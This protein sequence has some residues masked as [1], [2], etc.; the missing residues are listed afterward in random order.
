[1][2]NILRT[3]D[4]IE[5]GQC[6]IPQTQEL[7]YGHETAVASSATGEDVTVKDSQT[8]PVPRSKRQRQRRLLSDDELLGEF[9]SGSGHRQISM[10]LLPFEDARRIREATVIESRE[11]AVADAGGEG[12]LNPERPL[13]RKL[14]STMDVEQFTDDDF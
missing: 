5:R 3:L 8:Q 9:S 7:A 1:M 13:K 6:R 2:E 11:R 4:R 10:E 14:L 12:A